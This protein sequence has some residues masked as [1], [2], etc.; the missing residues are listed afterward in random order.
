[1]SF[2]KKNWENKGESGYENSKV[3][4]DNLNDLED[5][6]SNIFKTQYYSNEAIDFNNFN[7]V[8]FFSFDINCTFENGPGVETRPV[9]MMLVLNVSTNAVQV[10]FEG[11]KHIYFRVRSWGTWDSSWVT[12]Y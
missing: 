2:V 8:G 10:F 6:I 5:R 12:I 7:D 11:K 9:C 4:A 1:M 3:N